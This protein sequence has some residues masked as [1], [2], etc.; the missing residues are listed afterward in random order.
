MIVWLFYPAV[1][2]SA[3]RLFCGGIWIKDG[4]MESS[5]VKK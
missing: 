3:E 1:T 4:L 5:I 2:G